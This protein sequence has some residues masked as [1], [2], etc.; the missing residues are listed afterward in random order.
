[1]AWWL[2]VFLGLSLLILEVH[3][4]GGF[5]LMFFGIGGLLVGLLTAFGLEAPWLQW[6]LFT[7]LSVATL[8]FFRPPIVRRLQSSA[9]AIG[10]VD[11]LVGEQAIPSEDIPPGAVGKA[12]LRGTSWNARSS[13][14][15]LLAKGTRCRVER[16]DG[17]TLWLRAE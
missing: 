11:T 4:F 12:E 2:W 7:V 5:Y 9:A 13:A 15:A 6:L 8:V 10:P 14:A 1:M 17:L 16:V 3:T